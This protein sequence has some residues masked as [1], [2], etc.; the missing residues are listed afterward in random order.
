M[1]FAVHFLVPI[2]FGVVCCILFCFFFIICVVIDI[3]SH[4]YY[5]H[6][7][8]HRLAQKDTAHVCEAQGDRL[9]TGQHHD[10]TTP[11]RTQ[12]AVVASSCI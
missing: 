6:Y 10:V 12:G 2:N 8:R 7:H 3:V 9:D 1:L 5:C 11:G 4:D